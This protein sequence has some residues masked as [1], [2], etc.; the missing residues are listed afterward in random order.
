[1]VDPEIKDRGACEYEVLETDLATSVVKAVAAAAKPLR[2][3]GGGAIK[4]D[5]AKGGG[6][7][8]IKIGSTPY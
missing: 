7:G 6:G 5:S 1:M 4:A 2:K 8:T 3:G